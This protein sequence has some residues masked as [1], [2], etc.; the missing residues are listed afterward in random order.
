[1]QPV[2]WSEPNIG[3]EELG[4]FLEQE[5]ARRDEIRATVDAGNGLNRPLQVRHTVDIR[6]DDDDT[7][8][9]TQGFW[10]YSGCLSTDV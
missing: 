2:I 9:R 10:W 7:R 6:F 5:G 3:D 4:H 1:M 8:R